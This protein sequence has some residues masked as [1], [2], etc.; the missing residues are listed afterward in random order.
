MRFVD[1]D[2]EAEKTR[3]EIQSGNV[4]IVNL[5]KR[6]ASLLITNI[7]ERLVLIT[8]GFKMPRKE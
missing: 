4:D 1:L 2:K 8:I 3:D 5:V 6:N 7:L